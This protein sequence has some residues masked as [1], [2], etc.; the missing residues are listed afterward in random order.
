MEYKAKPIISPENSRSLEVCI[1]GPTNAGKS[2]LI[3]AFVE[4]QLSAV[5]E[6]ANTTYDTKMGILTDIE[7]K[8]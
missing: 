7:K 5:S 2:S 6:K 3:N 1:I 8:T 4:K